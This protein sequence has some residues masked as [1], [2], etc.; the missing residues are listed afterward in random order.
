MR[1][2]AAH[3]AAPVPPS[4][5]GLTQRT[6]GSVHSRAGLTAAATSDSAR[7]ADLAAILPLL[8]LTVAILPSRSVNYTKLIQKLP[9]IPY[10]KICKLYIPTPPLKTHIMKPMLKKVTGTKPHDLQLVLPRNIK[11]LQLQ[12]CYSMPRLIFLGQSET[13]ILLQNSYNRS[14]MLMSNYNRD[15]HTIVLA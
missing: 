7:P 1:T 4:R 12:T 3:Q 6:E 11:K 15:K 8:S 2:N 5:Y 13:F 10:S 9:T 14:T